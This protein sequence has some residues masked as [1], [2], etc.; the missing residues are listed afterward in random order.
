MKLGIVFEGGA[1][2]TTF[3]CGVMDALLELNIMADYIIGVSAGA[4]YGVS[5]ASGQIDVTTI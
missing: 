1:L 4:S 2:R 5:Y 3:S